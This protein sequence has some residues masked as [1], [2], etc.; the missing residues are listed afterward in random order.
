ML[1]FR[2]RRRDT[3]NLGQFIHG[4]KASIASVQDV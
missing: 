2:P 3:R 1:A 4:N